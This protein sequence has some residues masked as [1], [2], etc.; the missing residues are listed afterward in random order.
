[1]EK[2]NRLLSYIKFW[3]DLQT[4]LLVGRNSAKFR[5]GIVCAD[6]QTIDGLSPRV[7]E[8]ITFYLCIFEYS[9]VVF[10]NFDF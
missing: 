7:L 6:G 9:K 8:F 1:M 10:I 2:K 4:L 3:S 5:K